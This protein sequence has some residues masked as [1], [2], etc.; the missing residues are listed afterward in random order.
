M[1]EIV[2]GVNW[3][4]VIVGAVAAFIVGWLWYSP[5][6]F[7][8]QWA[9]GK[10]IEMGTASEMPVAAMATQLIG[11]FLLS[12]FVGVTAASD[13]LLTV[14]LA[15]IAFAVLAYSG[16]MFA[17]RSGVVRNVDFG[18]LLVSV[19]VMIVCQGIF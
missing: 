5:M 15:T 11:L 1:A 12:W 7:G 13:S 9:A 2:D 4:A 14:I 6:L 19:L 8:K 16:S 10:G 18:Y 17:K 3:L